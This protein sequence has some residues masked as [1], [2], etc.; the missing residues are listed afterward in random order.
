MKSLFSKPKTSAP[1]GRNGF[2]LSQRRLFTSSTGMMLPVYWDL[3]S[4]GDSYKLGSDVFIRT[5]A[6]E[7]SA[8]TRFKAHLDF[9]FVPLRQV[10]QFFGS[11]FNTIYD[12]DSDFLPDNA[13]GVGLPVANMNVLKYFESHSFFNTGTSSKPKLSCD[14]FGTPKIWHARRLYDMLGYGNLSIQ[15]FSDETYSNILPYLAYHKIFYSYYN[16]TD[17]FPT[18]PRL[19]NIDSIHGNFIPND[20]LFPIVSKLHYRP[21]RSDYFNNVFPSPTFDDKYSNFISF[22]SSP[23]GLREN[24][25]PEYSNDRNGILKNGVNGADGPSLQMKPASTG[26]Q[27]NPADLRSVFAFERLQRVNASASSAHYDSQILAHFGVKV[28]EGLSGD[29]YFIG[30]NV[31]DVNISEVVSTAST[32]Q[33][34]PGGIIGD[35]AGK[36][37]GH[38]TSDPNLEFTAKEHGIL[39][40]IF[41]IEPIID[42][43]SRAIDIV[44]RYR[45]PL[46]FYHP[47]LDNLGMQPQIPYI[48]DGMYRG[49][50]L[51]G[52]Q[53]RY[54]ELKT[55]YDVVNEGFY[56]SD[57]VSWQTNYQ[58]SLAEVGYNTTSRHNRFFINPQYANSIFALEYPYFTS[59]TA[60]YDVADTES[61]NW[62]NDFN[63]PLKIYSGD[64]FLCCSEIKCFKTSIMSVHSLPRIY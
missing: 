11:F 1:E 29:S 35:I 19:F 12:S 24:I 42:Y 22:I 45:R 16:N 3:A 50:Q 38:S 62:K 40:C 63:N 5:E 34:L 13:S 26:Y 33:D 41:S 55:K 37:F 53:Y 58:S 52:W 56:L 21:W 51:S 59:N 28:P 60:T 47:E 39:M 25:N 49:S 9:H 43:D 14:E 36:G 57:K 8:F 4:P 7:T 23:E 2:D 44:T 54:S 10:F 18:E 20:R 30:S 31:V 61:S 17:W 46:D 32:G 15:N 48:L 27:I 64:N 6:V